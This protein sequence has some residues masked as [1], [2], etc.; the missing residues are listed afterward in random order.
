MPSHV[1]LFDKLQPQVDKFLKDYTLFETVAHSE[2]VNDRIGHNVLLF[3]RKSPQKESNEADFQE[4][5]EP[6]AQTPYHD[7]LPELWAR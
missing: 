6:S 5:I 3:E 4:V 7:E 1:V 2:Y